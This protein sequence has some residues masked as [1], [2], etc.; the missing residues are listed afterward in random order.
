M[1]VDNQGNLYLADAGNEVIRKMTLVGTNWVVT[2][3]AGQPGVAGSMDGIGNKAQFNNPSGI[4]VDSLGRVFVADTWNNE[5]RE[6]LPD[7]TVTT[8]AGSANFLCDT[9]YGTIC[10]RPAIFHQQLE[11]SPAVGMVER[12]HHAAVDLVRGLATDQ[13]G[14]RK[15]QRAGD[16]CSRRR[17]ASQVLFR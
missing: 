9:L 2:T 16:V 5:I 4:A 15:L 3:L 14:S 8:I 17:P 10:E 6:I 11:L 1:A 12:N 13:C 7:G